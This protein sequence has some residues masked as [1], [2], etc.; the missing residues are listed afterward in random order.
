[1][2]HPKQHIADLPAILQQKGLE[3]VVISPGS[4]SA[5]LIAA[6][7]RV[8][9]ENCLSIADERSAAYYALGIAL[10]T[11]K[12]VAIICTSGTAA[13]NYAPA[14]AEAYYQQ[15]P[16]LAITADRS[17]EWI[18]QQ[19]NQTI[20]QRDI[21][22][23]FVK[24]SF[25]M[26]VAMAYPDN[27]WHAHRMS[28]E[29]FDLC[30]TSCKGPVHINVPLAEPLYDELPQV[31]ENLRLTDLVVPVAKP[32]LPAELELEWNKANSILIIHGQ[33]TPNSETSLVLPALMSDPRVVILA[34]NIANIPASGIISTS[35]LVLS[36]ARGNNPPYPDL[37]IHSG[38]QVVSKALAGYLRRAAH[39]KLWRV[40]TDHK[41]I[42][43]YKQAARYLH[44]PAH[45]FY[46]KLADMLQKGKQSNWSRQWH[47]IAETTRFKLTET[48]SQ[49][50]FTDSVVFEH[51]C[52]SIPDDTLVVIGNSSVIRY[53]Q[54]FSSNLTAHYYANRG[55]SGIDG[56]L[57][58]ASGIAVASG[59]PTL[60]ILGDISFLYDSNA[61]WNRELPQNLRIVVI[62]NQGGG[63]F[64]ILKGP[65]E[66]PGFKKLIE[67]H[68]PVNIH[69]L[70]E[71]YGLNYFYAGD[72][73]SLAAVWPDFVN[74]NHTAS[75]LE[76]VTD[77]VVSATAFRRLMNL[78]G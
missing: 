33:D 30:L 15:V 69:K 41:L 59:K 72:I 52:S 32:E 57:S 18:D 67:A 22:Q 17:P 7:Y 6:F 35:N 63:I 12:P 11:G 13:L 2:I 4:R 8:F 24:K 75:V 77:P 21:Y 43:T 28:N 64:H 29:A 5:P 70:A 45:L 42:D 60:A 1:M 46:H 16:L 49:L 10:Y 74:K 23:P 71:A 39:L 3:H 20:R 47:E 14:L 36:N 58:T 62:N 40:G 48:L 26:P 50:P 51:V 54:L 66:K 73:P 76:I 78:W 9:G 68:H 31:S 19:D 34:E 44:V 27:L 56:T 38:G 61:L 37:V 65:S 53:A 25:E 55:V